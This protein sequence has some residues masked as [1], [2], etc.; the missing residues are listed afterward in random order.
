[1]DV[2][3]PVN[4]ER[5]EEIIHR[6]LEV[7]FARAEIFQLFVYPLELFLGLVAGLRGHGGLHLSLLARKFAENVMGY[8]AE[9]N[10]HVCAGQRCMLPENLGLGSAHR[11]K[12]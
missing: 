6:D 12:K 11:G 3:Q 8:L 7:G 5:I 4:E 9:T 10:K 2:F 1:M